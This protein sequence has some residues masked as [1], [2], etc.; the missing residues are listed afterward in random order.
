MSIAIDARVTSVRTFLGSVASFSWLEFKTLRYYPSNLLLSLVEGTVNTGI[1]LFI[2]I[3]LKD[4]ADQAVAG[5]GGSYVAYVVIGVS[6]FGAAQTALTSPFESVSQAFWDKRLEAY[7][8]ASDGIWANILGRMGWQLLYA[9]A[10]QVAVVALIVATVGID[11]SPSTSPLLTLL[12]FVL[13]VCCCFGLGLV[14]A[15]SFFLL[16]VKEGSEPV[17]WGVTV[18]A[19]IASGVY[20]PLSIIPVWMRP[21]GWLVPHTYALRSIR[22]VLIDG[23]GLDDPR[24]VIDMLILVC[25]AIAA[26][27]LGVW[28]LRRGIRKAERVGGMSVVG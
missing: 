7:H 11:F 15:S 5:F 6:F 13:F 1:W 9:T 14:G 23:H 3:F 26:I 17:T 24:I 28:M 2:G 12:L 22:L 8:M 10:I 25:Y 21:L 18:I 4:V 19:R 20:Y 27:T 16:E